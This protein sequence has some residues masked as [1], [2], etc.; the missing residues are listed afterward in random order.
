[1]L[2]SYCQSSITTTRPTQCNIIIILS[3]ILLSVLCHAVAV[4]ICLLESRSV[5]QNSRHPS[6]RQE[7]EK[8]IPRQNVWAS[9][10]SHSR[11]LSSM[12]RCPFEAHKLPPSQKQKKC[13]HMRNSSFR[14]LTQYIDGANENYYLYFQYIGNAIPMHYVQIQRILTL[15]SQPTHIIWWFTKLHV[16]HRKRQ[17]YNNTILYQKKT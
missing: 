10:G 12:L 11:A 17:K 9:I 15:T 6:T 14:L 13:K 5:L 1:M 16:L 4:T 7:I 8:R 2:S 3:R